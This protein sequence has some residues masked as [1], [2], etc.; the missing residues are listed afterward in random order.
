MRNNVFLF[1]EGLKT[2]SKDKPIVY[3][4]KMSVEVLSLKNKILEIKITTSKDSLIK[5]VLLNTD[6][7]KYLLNCLRKFNNVLHT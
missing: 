3:F 4:G 5:K 2:T 7:N 1:G 6:E